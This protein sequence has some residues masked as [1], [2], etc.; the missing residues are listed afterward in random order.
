M[1]EEL[2]KCVNEP[3]YS[4]KL[5]N[6]IKLFMYPTNKTKNFYI[7]ITVKYG[8]NVIKYK[9]DNKTIDVLPGSAH[10]LEHKVMALSENKR[11]SERINNLGSLANAWTSYFGTNYNIYGS[12]N[13]LENIKLLLDIFYN[14]DINPKN[15]SKEKGIINEEIDMYKDNISGYLFDQL[16]KNMFHNSYVKSTVVGEH[17]DI[18]KMTSK[19]LNK[20]YDD[21]YLPN[22]TFIV[23]CGNFDTYEV[24]NMINEYI[25]HL[26]LKEKTLPKRFKG[27][28]KDSVKVDYQEIK[29]DTTN[30]YVKYGVKIS[31]KLFSIKDDFLLKNYLYIIL[32]CNFS[33]TSK[34]YEK[35]KNNGLILSMSYSVS[36]IDD[37]VS[38]V[39]SARTN[40]CDEFIKSI[41][42]DFNNIKISE[43]EFERKKKIML[44][45]EILTFDNIEDVEYIITQDIIRYNKILYNAFED[46]KQMKYS[47]ALEF[48]NHI[49]NTYHTIIKTIK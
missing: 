38:V 11:I 18:E 23:I 22:N 19:S 16:Y 46:I 35:Y 41:N 47:I 43:H 45:N 2:F 27:K 10:F 48:S 13:I 7:T 25:S 42:N 34:L 40:K 5:D 29:K 33:S 39:I 36:I 9:L 26:N 8:A 24:Y 15:V 30:T 32:G 49:K 31:K 17:S 28:E 14:T 21:Y 44:R 1:K 3:I 37:Y 6:G 20:I 4:C 12:V